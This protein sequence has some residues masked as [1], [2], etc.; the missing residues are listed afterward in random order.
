MKKIGIFTAVLLVAA[1]LAAQTAPATPQKPATG[2]QT[3]AAAPPAGTPAAPKVAKT[4]EA[5][6]PEE[7]KAYQEVAQVTD[8]NAGEVAADEFAK[9][10][11][12][13]ELRVNAY[14]VVLQKAYEAGNSDKVIQIGR[15]FLAIDPES[16]MTLVV[17]A[18]ALAETTK[19]TD[20]DAEQK[21]EEANKYLNKA[22]ANIE[23]MLPQPGVTPD[24]FA[25]LQSV[26][27]NMAY[28]AK[29]YL[30]MN[31]KDFPGAEMAFQ[32]AIEATPQQPDPTLY[33]RLAVTQDSQKK[34][35][36]AFANATKAMQI[37]Q[38]QNNMVVA[39]LARGERD[40]VQKLMG[41]APATPKQ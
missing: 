7:F 1:T 35:A 15:K 14:G 26:L 34:F 22:V 29:G 10:Y 9:K 28:A 18:T 8:I 12:Q 2:Q 11:P 6:T 32:K 40:R 17:T 25:N 38:E 4:P 31:K 36:P 20:L 21:T 23:T 19:D 37:A 24:Q 39:N 5:K 3:P 30:A 13:S 41:S 16:P 33:L 27:R